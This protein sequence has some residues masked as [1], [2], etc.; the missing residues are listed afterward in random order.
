ME[1][2]ITPSSFVQADSTE[3]LYRT[4]QPDGK[5][6][7]AIAATALVKIPSLILRGSHNELVPQRPTLDDARALLNDAGHCL[8]VYRNG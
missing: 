6:R 7:A 2:A 8:A 1:P 3:M 4:W 5:P